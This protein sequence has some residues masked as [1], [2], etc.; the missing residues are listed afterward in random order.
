MNGLSLTRAP[1]RRIKLKQATTLYRYERGNATPYDLQLPAG[2]E[3]L[4]RSRLLNDRRTRQHNIV[5]RDGAGHEWLAARTIVAPWE[6]GC[7][8]GVWYQATITWPQKLNL[9]YTR[10]GEQVFAMVADNGNRLQVVMVSRVGNADGGYW[11]CDVGEAHRVVRPNRSTDGNPT[12][13]VPEDVEAML[14]YYK[15]W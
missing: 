14:S 3:V 11:V 4:Y 2:T 13:A 1:I 9:D 8:V 10:N 5:Y 12:L 6:D 15:L 7:E